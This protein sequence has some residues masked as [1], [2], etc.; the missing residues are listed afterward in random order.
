MDILIISHFGS[1]YSE[2]DNDRFLYLANL[3]TQNNNVEIVTSS[4]CHEKKVHRNQTEA[5]WPFKITFIEEPG[6]KRNV[7]IKRFYSH[8]LFGL[9]LYKYIS[10]RK[11]PDV[12]YCAVPSLTG[13]YFIS[14]YCMKNSIKF[15][16]DIQDLWPEAFKMIFNVPILSD[17]VFKPFVIMANAIYKNADDIVA[18]SQTYV[19]RA[20]KVN[21][22]VR[23]GVS[24]FL[25]TDLERYDENVKEN[26]IISC[27]EDIIRIGYCGTLGS[28]YDIKCVID[29]LKIIKE[30]NKQKVQFVLMGD[31]PKKSEFEEYAKQKEVD[32]C[33][34]GRV[35]YDQMCALIADCDIV[36][37]PIMRRAAQS[38]INK[39]ADY[40]ASGH[41]V[42]NTQ[43]ADEYRQLVEKY[44]RGFNCKNGEADDLAAK[45]NLLIDNKELRYRMGKNARR[46]AEENFDRKRTYKKIEKVIL[47]E[48]KS[49]IEL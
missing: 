39:H 30:N 38:I 37:N 33:F 46:C 17:F 1:T 26:K 14:K 8:Y 29:A 5:S 28:S 16:V 47:G 40:A 9:N 25:G 13:P 44:E 48:M 34:K 19:E 32:C 35:P 20:I 22:K 21:K 41:P 6:Y 43:E 3:L 27:Q 49:G 7:C 45:I 12:I 2:T 23:Q 36:V 15:V 11:K 18:V 31:G 10:N 24:I 42:V 4:F